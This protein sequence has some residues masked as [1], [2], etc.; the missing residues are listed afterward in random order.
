MQRGDAA[1]PARGRLP[2]RR[3]Q[4]RVADR[5]QPARGGAQQRD[6]HEGVRDRRGR[7]RRRAR[8]CWSRRTRPSTRRP[9]SARRRRWR[10]GSSRRYG[11]RYPDT[12]FCCVRFGNVL[13]SSGSVVPLFRRQIEQGGPVT[14]TAS[15]HGALLHDGPGGR[16][17]D[18]PGRQPRPRRRG[19]RARDG[20]A[21][22][23]HRPRA[24]HD[25]ALRPGGRIATSRSRSS[26]R[27]RARSCAR[28]SS[29]K[30]SGR[31]RP[32]PTAS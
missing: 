12:V 31:C 7:G 28:S 30:A 10:S 29:T 19:V 6:R 18:H 21:G 26:A 23:D 20:R 15:R 9:R 16:A 27:G 14:V 2:R 4:A 17:A 8:S 24:Q 3:L 22:E 25:P 13:G 5:G 32:R 1:L 11:H